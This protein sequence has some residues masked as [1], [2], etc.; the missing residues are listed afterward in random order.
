MCSMELHKRYRESVRSHGAGR[1]GSSRSGLP[2]L[3]ALLLIAGMECSALPAPSEVRQAAGDYIQQNE[4]AEG[5]EKFTD[6][7]VDGLQDSVRPGRERLALY[8]TLADC[9]RLLQM[10]KKEPLSVETLDWI[11][12]SGNRT[13]LLV[14]TIL[15]ADR[16][17]ECFGIVDQLAKHNPE[18][19]DDY[20][21]L[22]LAMA[23]VWDAP[24]RSPMHGQMGD[25]VLPYAPQLEERYDYFRE[26]Y[27][28]DEAKVA[29][30]D[31]SVYDL[32]FVVDTPV[33]L[34]E[35]KWAREHVDGS[36]G[37][38]GRKFQEIEYDDIRVDR[39]QF[40]WPYGLYTLA[41]IEKFGGICVDQA[42]YCVMTARA[43]G[44]PAIYFSAVGAQGGHAW[45]SYLRAE[46][47]WELDIGRYESG[48]YTTGESIS[49][50]TRRAMTDHDVEYACERSIRSA[51]QQKAAYYVALAE[52]VR[53]KDP[54]VAL[55]C[56]REARKLFGRNLRA[57]E[58]ELDILAEQKA[59]DDLLALFD[60]QKDVYRKYPD[61][62]VDT[63]TEII[64]V[65]A[66]EGR[67]E[68]M[69]SLQKSLAGVV[70]DDRDD[71][72]RTLELV[73]INQIYSSGEYE[74]A[75]REFEQ[76]LDD[77]QQEA[78]KVPPLL[79]QYLEMANHAGQQQ[80]AAEFIEDYVEE[81]R[82]N[83]DLYPHIER[84]FLSIQLKAW[85]YADDMEGVERAVMLISEV[86]DTD[87]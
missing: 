81:I 65:L 82:R 78:A 7:L 35:L 45:F 13:H 57:W 49:P 14:E 80:D 52:V 43:Y 75:R 83:N 19:R 1:G 74:K 39:E 3:T 59:C 67:D 77:Q 5:I 72:G 53:E 61:I 79:S 33:P 36:I 11:L 23:V 64:R 32:I 15:P 66:S 42:Y 70:D 28:T 54:A 40:S 58:L 68:D 12:A 4:Q 46:R 73:R 27:Q 9:V 8:G 51:D 63:A 85:S 87:E 56:T 31:L 60:A 18:D 17:K 62:L 55:A 2:V 16:L 71:I 26:L 69:V 34:A 37:T 48:N 6:V 76:L 20:F 41:S 44:I 38:W 22:I 86:R 10:T 24:L 47:R 30:D 84:Q 25:E 50:Q 21:E 29:Y